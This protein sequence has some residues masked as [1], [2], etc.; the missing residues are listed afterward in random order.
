[1][2]KLLLILTASSALA[3]AGNRR[4]VT[5]GAIASELVCALDACSEIVATDV[6]SVY[7]P[8]LAAK[9][10]VGYIT[11]LSSEGILALKPTHLVAVE[12]AGPAA[13]LAQLKQS[14]VSIIT[15]PAGL[16]LAAADERLALL[17]EFTGNTGQAKRLRKKL[18]ADLAQLSKEAARHKPVK[19]LFIYARGAQTLLA[20][21]SNTTAH[22][23]IELAGIKNAFAAEGAKP[24][25]A[26]AIAAA[27]PEV[28]IIPEGSLAGLGG[29]EGLKKIPGLAQT[30]AGKAARVV[31]LDDSLLAGLGP[32]SGIAARTLRQKI[33]EALQSSK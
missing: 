20:M 7:P 13:V 27:A 33:R 14:G 2:K 18:H 28:V 19:V 4:I 21:G 22:E 12:G 15:I 26:E 29:V 3:A 9:P 24:V 8:E 23:L 10:K 32:R 5:V 31:A 6:T 17:G 16:G 1:M 25:N 30:P 11:R